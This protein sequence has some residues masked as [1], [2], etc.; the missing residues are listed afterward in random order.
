MFQHDEV[1]EDFELRITGEESRATGDRERS[2]ETIGIG[3]TISGLDLHGV[4]EKVFREGNNS[5]REKTDFASRAKRLL[6]AT[7]FPDGVDDLTQVDDVKQYAWTPCLRV[8]ED[9]VDLLGP[10]FILKQAEERAGIK[11]DVMRAF[12]HA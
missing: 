5:E 2:R 7:S 4:P 6:P 10:R 9:A 11:D 12:A 3:H 1:S 8:A